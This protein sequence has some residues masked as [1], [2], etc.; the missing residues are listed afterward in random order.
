MVI[1]FLKMLLSELLVLGLLRGVE[2]TRF[3]Q[4]KNIDPSGRSMI[5]PITCSG[6]WR[7]IVVDLSRT[8]SRDWAVRR[9]C[10]VLPR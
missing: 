5:V 6:S 1:V 8:R 7:R 10:G 9:E 4:F 3:L 2:V